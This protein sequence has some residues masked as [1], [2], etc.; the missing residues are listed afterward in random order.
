MGNKFNACKIALE[1]VFTEIKKQGWLA[2]VISVISSIV[3][4]LLDGDLL[5][6]GAFLLTILG[7]IVFVIF[8]WSFIF[9]L[10]EYGK[11]LNVPS[12]QKRV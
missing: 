8:I 12:R 2:L 11:T 3:S 5:K 1:H 4:F 10:E 9:I 6:A 7:T